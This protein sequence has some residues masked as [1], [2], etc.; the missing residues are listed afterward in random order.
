MGQRDVGLPH[1]HALSQHLQFGPPDG[2]EGVTL[3]PEPKA[4][5][6][7]RAHQKVPFDAGIQTVAFTTKDI[8][9][10]FERLR[11][12]GVVFRSEPTDMGLITAALFED[13][14]GNLVYLV[15]PTE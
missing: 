11:G 14:C 5:P 10:E 13:T 15:Q 4:F 7:A 8:A 3:V 9:A 1:P 12:L 2:V 6:P